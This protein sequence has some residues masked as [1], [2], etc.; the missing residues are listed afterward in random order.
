MN[1]K[2]WTVEGAENV[3]DVR[4]DVPNVAVPVG[5]PIGFQLTAVFQSAEAIPVHVASF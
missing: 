5:A 2:V 1:D 4:V 3:S